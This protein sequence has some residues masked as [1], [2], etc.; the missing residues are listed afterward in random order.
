[1][2]SEKISLK[3]LMESFLAYSPEIIRNRTIPDISLKSLNKMVINKS[4]NELLDE[5]KSL[6]EINK[7]YKN[8]ILKGENYE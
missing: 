7:I 3:D 8:N 1:M 6:H 4:L 5:G 2:G